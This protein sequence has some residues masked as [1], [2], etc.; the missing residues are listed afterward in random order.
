MVSNIM[1][2]RGIGVCDGI[3]ASLILLKVCTMRH[4]PVAFSTQS[5]GLECADTLSG[6]CPA[7]RRLSKKAINGFRL[8]ARKRPLSRDAVL[9]TGREVNLIRGKYGGALLWENLDELADK[10]SNWVT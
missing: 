8:V 7:Q 1:S 4:P 2:L 9:G 3:V 10:K 5:V 6:T